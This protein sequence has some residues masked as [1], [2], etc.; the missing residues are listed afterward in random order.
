MRKSTKKDSSVQQEKAVKKQLTP[1]EKKKRRR[2]IVNTIMG[3]I[4][5]FGL[6]CCLSG[7]SVVALVLE[8]CDVVLD[9]NDLAAT[10][11]TLIYDD[12][13]ELIYTVGNET[14]ISVGYDQMPQVV[15]DA[16]VSIEDSRFFEHNG[17]D[18]PRFAKAL[19]E[20]IKTLSFA[21]G[22]STITMQV[23]KN[24]YF[25][26]D[27]IAEKSITRK[28]QEI[29][30]SLKINELVSKEKIIEI[31]INRVNYGSSARGI[32]VAAQYYFGKD[33]TDLTLVEAAML[34]GI[35]NAPNQYNPYY[36]LEACQ[37]RTAT[38]LYQM[39][40]HGY[41]TEEEYKVA[42]EV[43]IENL[44][45]GSTTTTYG[46]GETVDYLAYVDVVLAELEDTYGI[47]PYTTPVRIYTAMNKTVQE[48]C[49]ELARGNV[50]EFKDEY[51]N[52]SVVLIQNGTGRIVGLCGG[53]DYDSALSFSYAY[54]NRIN[55][56]S[57]SKAVFTYPLAFEYAGVGTN[58]YIEDGPTTWTGSTT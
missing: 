20:N 43:K 9:T 35:V 11:S 10:D 37:E 52:T 8:K 42:L 51:V 22:G 7:V 5:F 12:Q 26:V 45:V 32:Q 14:R 50:V 58:T 56:G 6:L 28:I 48:Y 54:D 49:D 41:I 3:V 19:I 27:T 21:Q 15:I 30:Y 39:Y 16:F 46:T 2:K 31:Y 17:F 44:L 38:V 40:S 29:Y 36:H 24:T 18:V 34:A 53:R 23:I 1:F 25:A 47:D 55:P 4:V 33:T 57:V 13:G